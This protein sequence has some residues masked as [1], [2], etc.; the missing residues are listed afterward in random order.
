MS[1]KVGQK[2]SYPNHGVCAIEGVE[3]KK[4][5]N[6]SVDFYSLRVLAFNSLILV[7][8]NNAESIGIRPLISNDQSQKVL[9]YLSKDFD[10]IESDWKIRI[11]DYIATVQ[12]GEIFA[13]AD[14][15][16]KLTFLTKL[17]TLSFR[18]QRL[19]EKTKFLIASEIATASSK[20]MEEIEVKVDKFV[21]KACEKH[22]INQIPMI[23]Q[24]AH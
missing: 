8:M 22:S 14:V 23:S 13:V 17:K 10:E 24:V 4:I 16:K 1:F 15:L 5:S 2:V 18:E 20:P 6:D 19:L 3:S 11:R 21:A 9:S 7:P 12:T